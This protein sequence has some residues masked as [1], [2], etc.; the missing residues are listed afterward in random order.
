MR[1]RNLGPSKSMVICQWLCHGR[2][3]SSKAAQAKVDNG[4]LIV[5]LTKLG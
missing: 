5:I 1:M 4:S 3:S 2:G